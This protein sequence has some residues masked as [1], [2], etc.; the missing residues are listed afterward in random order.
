MLRKLFLAALFTFSFSAYA[1]IN[2]EFLEAA[3]KGEV[4]NISELLEK[5]ADLNVKNKDGMSQE[6][7]KRIVQLLEKAKAKEQMQNKPAN[8]TKDSNKEKHGIRS[9]D[10][11]FVDNNGDGT[12]T[13]TN[14][15]LM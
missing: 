8:M 15:G 2:S 14:I 6:G 9:S 5:G 13:D 3:A 10:G 1:D 12:V 11:R 4:A 7:H